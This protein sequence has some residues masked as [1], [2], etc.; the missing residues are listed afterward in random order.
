MLAKPCP[1][2]KELAERPSTESG[3]GWSSIQL[4]AGHEWCSPGLGFGSGLVVGSGGVL[5]PGGV[6]KLCRCGTW[7]HGL[8]G[9]VVLGGWLDSMILV[10]FS[11]L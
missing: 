1:K 8:A 6:Q 10:V 3:G 11:N 2:D 5:I 7:G 9:M 4:A